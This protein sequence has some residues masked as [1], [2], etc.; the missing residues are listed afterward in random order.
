[1][2]EI[3]DTVDGTPEDERPVGAMPEAA[4]KEDDE[5][6]ANPFCFGDTVTAKRN[7]EIVTEPGG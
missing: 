1:M 6:I 5:L 2:G 7:I 4:Q 3:E